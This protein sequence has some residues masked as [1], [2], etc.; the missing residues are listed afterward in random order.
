MFPKRSKSGWRR[1]LPSCFRKDFFFFFKG[2]G[3]IRRA[4]G[5]SGKIMEKSGEIKIGN[6]RNGLLCTKTCKNASNWVLDEK[7][8]QS[9]LVYTSQ[10]NLLTQ[11]TGS[12]RTSYL[13]N[14][15]FSRAGDVGLLARKRQAASF[16]QKRCRSARVAGGLQG[17]GVPPPLWGTV[18]GP[19]ECTSL[20]PSGA[21]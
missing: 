12:S 15:C 21:P 4:K 5:G 19:D 8:K 18:S 10:V 9:T 14:Q 2:V 6:E 7:N 17:A 1:V 20:T 13:M 3:E 11:H 16:L